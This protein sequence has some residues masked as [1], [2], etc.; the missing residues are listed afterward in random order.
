MTLNVTHKLSDDFLENEINILS[1][2]LYYSKKT[3]FEEATI[4]H[5]MTEAYPTGGHTQ[6]LELFM[7]NCSQ[8][9]KKQDIVISTQNTPLPASIMN[10]ASKYGKLTLLDEMSILKKAQKLIDMSSDFHYIMLHIHPHDIVANLAYGSSKFTRPILFLNHADHMFWCGVSISDI[11]LE[12]SEQGKKLS[13]KYRGV[14]L[15]NVVHIPIQNST[16]TL[17]K[18]QARDKLNIDT[19]KKMILTIANEAKFGNSEEDVKKFINMALNIVNNVDDC[20]YYFIGPSATSPYWYEANKLSQGKIIPVGL[21]KREQLPFYIRSCDLYIVSFP[22]GSHTALLEISLYNVNILRLNTAGLT[23]DAVNQ[24]DISMNTIEDLENKAISI[25]N[26][27]TEL[28]K[29]HI[30]K[31]LQP[32]WSKNMINIF[33][34]ISKT[35]HSI[36]RFKGEYLDQQYTKYLNSVIS[37][38]PF[39]DNSF[40][41]LPFKIKF[42]LLFAMRKNNMIQGFRNFRKALRKIIK[43]RNI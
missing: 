36:Y 25:L 5:V 24:A 15:N 23:I 11:V 34:E 27:P 42:K 1:E 9:F 19:N 35:K 28:N 8:Y 2:S 7:Q 22:F 30:Q 12:I 13:N 10:T 17:T 21:Q 18:A 31:Y 37:N 32:Q 14:L 3:T 6:Y 33:T 41:K 40:L 16:I 38:K 43:E 4:L 26:T 29:M 20:L 39:L